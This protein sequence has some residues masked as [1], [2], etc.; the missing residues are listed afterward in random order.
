MVRAG[1]LTAMLAL[2]PLWGGG[3]A[4]GEGAAHDHGAAAEPAAEHVRITL[5]DTELVE[6][7]GAAL[8][9][10]SEAVGDRIVAMNFVYTTCTTVCPV[11]TAML[12]Q[13]QAALAEAGIGEDE[14]RLI[15][16][17]VDPGRDTPERLAD[18]AEAMGVGP[19]W[20]WLTGHKPEVNALLED[21]GVY[22]ANYDDHPPVMLVGDARSGVWQRLYGFPAPEDVTRRIDELRH[23]RRH[24]H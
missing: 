6:R 3:A 17:T 20:L 21:L 10:A 5:P 19:G 16:V 11:S 1:I 9:F 18:Y 24:T 14:V 22:T 2:L 7:N 15:S 23:A 8:H 12:L 4:L 13:V